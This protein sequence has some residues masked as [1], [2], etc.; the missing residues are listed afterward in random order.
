MAEETASRLIGLPLVLSH[1]AADMEMFQFG[2]ITTVETR[3][4]TRSIGQM[5]LHIQCPWR[6]EHK[7]QILV[8]SAD[9]RYP[10]TGVDID[11]F[12]W[13]VPLSTRRDEFLELF[14]SHGDQA[15]AVLAAEVAAFGDLRLAFAD[16]CALMSI[17]CSGH[18]SES[19]YVHLDGEA[20]RLFGSLAH[21]EHLVCHASGLELQ[22]PVVGG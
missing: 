19:E 1:R 14:F 13:D 11:K 4:N 9:L 20:W 18:V 3:D 16:G 10:R 12:D 15:H 7:G 2:R 21:G 6:I 8:G 5:S 17:T 22:R